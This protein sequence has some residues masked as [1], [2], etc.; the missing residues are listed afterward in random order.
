[1][2]ILLIEAPVGVEPEAKRKLI[3]DVSEAIEDAYHFQD[4]RVWLREYSAENIAQDGRIGAEVRPV[5]FLEAPEL[6]SL[7]ARRKMAAGI[8]EAMSEAYSGLANTDETLVM[9]NHYP[10]ELAGFAGRLQADDPD[11]VAAV[12]ELNG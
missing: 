6:D 9:M 10:L 3:K 8:H 1:M 2:P 11:I 7:D 5:C 4:V 12:K